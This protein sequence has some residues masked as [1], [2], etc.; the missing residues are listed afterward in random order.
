LK[1]QS[2]LVRL[3]LAQLDKLRQMGV[4]RDVLLREAKVDDRQLRDPDGRI[5][6]E[7][8]PALGAPRKRTWPTRRWG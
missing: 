6:L 2:G 7:R 4:A 3:V 1:Q 5:P 8:W